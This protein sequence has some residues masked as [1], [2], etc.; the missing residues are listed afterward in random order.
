MYREPKRIRPTS[1]YCTLD[2]IKELRVIQN[3]LQRLA[4]EARTDVSQ[5]ILECIANVHIG[6]AVRK[7]NV[8][9]GRLAEWL[10][11]KWLD[12]IV[13]DNRFPSIMRQAEGHWCK[14][15]QAFGDTLV[16]F[17]DVEDIDNKRLEAL[18]WTA[19]RF[20]YIRL[21]FRLVPIAID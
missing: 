6:N 17:M 12:E 7:A 3:E 13:D 11:N 15:P 5:A 10:D 2:D 8:P 21:Q 16:A 4:D 20:N 9:V 18:V 1:R 14:N 19:P